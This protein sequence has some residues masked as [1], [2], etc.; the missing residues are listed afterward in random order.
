[1]CGAD[2]WH[3][4]DLKPALRGLKATGRGAC[5]QKGNF[6]VLRL[7]NRVL[8]SG[9]TLTILISVEQ[10]PRHLVMDLNPINSVLTLIWYY[11]TRLTHTL[12]YWRTVLGI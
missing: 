3:L 9:I 7:G 1:M 8:M 10:Y 2:T 12:D 11:V 6:R 4:L 5:T